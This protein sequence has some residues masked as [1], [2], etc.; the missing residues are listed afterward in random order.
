MREFLDQP[1]SDQRKIESVIDNIP[2]D[3][4][5]VFFQNKSRQEKQ[6]LSEDSRPDLAEEIFK[7]INPLGLHIADLKK[8]IENEVQELEL[9]IKEMESED[10]KLNEKIISDHKKEI[11]AKNLWI[12]KMNDFLIGNKLEEMEMLGSSLN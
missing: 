6:E 1:K 8:N 3:K 7:D 11:V 4:D 12:Q 9:S 5:G 2:K 10:P